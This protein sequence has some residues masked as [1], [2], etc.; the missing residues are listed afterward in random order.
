MQIREHRRCHARQARHRHVPIGGSRDVRRVGGQ[1][2]PVGALLPQG[3]VWSRVTPSR[4]SS[5][6]TRT[7]MAGDVGRSAGR[8]L[9]R[10]DQYP[11]VRGRGRVH[12]RRLAVKA[13]VGSAALRRARGT[14]SRACPT[15]CQNRCRSPTPT[16]TAGSATRTALPTSPIRRSTT[17]S[18]ATCCSTPRARPAAEGHQTRA[19]ARTAVRVARHDV[20]A[21]RPSGC[22]RRPS[23]SAP[24]RCTTRRLRCGR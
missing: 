7:C 21:G 16:P 19:S 2:E 13:I 15:P 5:R 17:R 22:I 12:H 3:P 9:L 11:P 14:G 23:T 4:S 20:G 18:R 10:P 8:S 24:R 6:T 1:G